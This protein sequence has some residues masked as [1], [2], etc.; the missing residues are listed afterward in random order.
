VTCRYN[1][2]VIRVV[3]VDILWLIYMFTHNHTGG[4]DRLYND[5]I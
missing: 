2:I 4:S 3:H 5:N 1:R